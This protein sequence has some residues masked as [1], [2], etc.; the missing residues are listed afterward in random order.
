MERD[1]VKCTRR[2]DCGASLPYSLFVCGLALL[3]IFP[4]LGFP[5]KQDL[6]LFF[7]QTETRLYYF[8][9][10]PGSRGTRPPLFFSMELPVQL[11]GRRKTKT[12]YFNTLKT[13]MGNSTP[14]PLKGT[15]IL[16]DQTEM[17]QKNSLRRFVYDIRRWKLMWLKVQKIDTYLLIS[18]DYSHLPVI[19]LI[20]SLIQS[21]FQTE[22]YPY[23]Q[24]LPGYLLLK[25]LR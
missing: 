10:R 23:S 2:I 7:R 18:I 8:K 9:W 13:A 3:F 5:R 25:T 14:N 15:R 22:R 16:W 24:Y 17:L 1:P 21:L 12:R 6:H 11:G 19:E 20:K 4:R